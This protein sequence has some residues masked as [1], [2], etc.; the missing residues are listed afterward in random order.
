MTGSFS[1]G[2]ALL[3]GVGTYKD[4]KISI[5]VTAQDAED[6]GK[7][8][9]D[10]QLCG[11]PQAQVTV[12]TNQD[13]NKPRILTELGALA[14]R[15]QGDGDATVIIFF[16]GHGIA[17]EDY[18]FLPHETQVTYNA[19]GNPSGIV[20]DTALS[21]TVFLGKVRQIQAKRLV[22]LFNTCCLL[23]TSPSPRDRTRS[24]MPSSA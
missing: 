15:V 4:T 14:Q 19:L 20:Y 2:H 22:I 9:T 16:A 1:H 17:N 5:P 23:Y 7:A 24:R 13:A 12:L 10:T 6:L 18:Y 3:I 21:N 11:Y 8:L